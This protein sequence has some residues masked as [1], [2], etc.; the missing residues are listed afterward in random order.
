MSDQTEIAILVHRDATGI[1]SD[2]QLVSTL[3]TV[4]DDRAVPR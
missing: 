3:D 4:A 2:H 1:A